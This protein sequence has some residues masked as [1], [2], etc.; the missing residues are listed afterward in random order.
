MI[1]LINKN[2]ATLAMLAALAMVL[3]ALVSL[4]WAGKIQGDSA[5]ATAFV[6]SVGSICGAIAGYSMRRTTDSTVQ[7]PGVQVTKNETG[8]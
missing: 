2:M 4:L 7:T 1:E 6:T 3:S 5:T 8:G